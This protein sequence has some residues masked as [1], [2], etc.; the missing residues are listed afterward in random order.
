VGSYSTVAHDGKQIQ[1]KVD[2]EENTLLK[3][4]EWR[5]KNEPMAEEDDESDDA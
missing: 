4:D 3:A 1:F 2:R 5:S